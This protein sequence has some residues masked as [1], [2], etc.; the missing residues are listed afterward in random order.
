MK[1]QYLLSKE[2]IFLN[3]GS[4]G[5]CPKPVFKEYQRWQTLLEKQPVQFMAH[6]IYKYL[7][8]A[9]D[10]LVFYVGCNGDDL[11]LARYKPAAFIF[12][13]IILI[14][15]FNCSPPYVFSIETIGPINFI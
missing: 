10:E 15:F 7:Q 6:D 13:A 5:A 14:L 9:R 3:H 4:F 11:F 2:V 12:P 1:D 8:Q